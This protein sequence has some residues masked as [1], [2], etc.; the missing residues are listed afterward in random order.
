[1]TSK[2][3]PDTSSCANLVVG[4]AVPSGRPAV[5]SPFPRLSVAASPRSA[6]WKG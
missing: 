1:M 6:P 2:A 4:G 3:P 5:S